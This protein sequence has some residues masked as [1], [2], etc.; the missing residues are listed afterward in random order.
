DDLQDRWLQVYSRVLALQSSLDFNRL[1]EMIGMKDPANDQ[2]LVEAAD[3]FED[4]IQKQ[5][6]DSLSDGCGY[7]EEQALAFFQHYHDQERGYNLS[8][9]IESESFA[10][11]VEMPGE[12]IGSNADRIDGSEAVWEFDGKALQDRDHELIISSRISN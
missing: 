11:S 12:I 5:L 1:A 8:E 9:D 2:A 6:R 7:T 3:R 4:S 10:V